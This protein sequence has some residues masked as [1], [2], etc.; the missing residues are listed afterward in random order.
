MREN[1]GEVFWRHHSL[2]PCTRSPSPR[3]SPVGR[4]RLR[5][6]PAGRCLAESSVWVPGTTLRPGGAY[7][8]RH[9]PGTA[10]RRHDRRGPKP[11]ATAGRHASN[12]ARPPGA[13]SCRLSSVLSVSQVE[14]GQGSCVRD[15]VRGPRR[16]CVFFCE[17]RN[18]HGGTKSLDVTDVSPA[19]GAGARAEWRPFPKK[20]RGL[21]ALAPRL[22]YPTQAPGFRRAT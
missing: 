10:P 8:L 16:R 21:A 17:C 18:R 20:T 22:R 9:G 15:S 14:A 13:V 5:V 6:S 12:R 1:G 19:R 7:T 11:D 3:P 2:G 4:G